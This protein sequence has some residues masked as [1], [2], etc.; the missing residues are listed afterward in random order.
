MSQKVI[1]TKGIIASG[2]S[3]FAE[4][5]LTGVIDH[6]PKLKKMIKKYAPEWPVDQISPVDRAVLYLGMYELF[7]LKEKETC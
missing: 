4:K 1:L 7:Y 3:T 6:V 5:L 2:K